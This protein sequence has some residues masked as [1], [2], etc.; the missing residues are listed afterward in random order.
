MLRP[1]HP[2][3]RKTDL[4]SDKSPFIGR[5]CAVYPVLRLHVKTLGSRRTSS[6]YWRP[7]DGPPR[8]RR[9]RSHRPGRPA[10]SKPGPTYPV[11]RSLSEAGEGESTICRALQAHFVQLLPLLNRDVVVDERV[12]G[13]HR[14]RYLDGVPKERKETKTKIICSSQGCLRET[15]CSYCHRSRRRAPF[16][17]V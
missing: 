16:R 15:C 3:L 7:P 5:W 12:C 10:R 13:R 17:R 11:G 4:T 9:D 2:C 8:S 6:D 1:R 14:G